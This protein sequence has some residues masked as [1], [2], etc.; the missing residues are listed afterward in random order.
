MVYFYQ[1]ILQI[2]KYIEI[3]HIHTNQIHAPHD[4]RRSAN[5]LNSTA[6]ALYATIKGNDHLAQLIRLI[7]SVRPHKFHTMFKYNAIKIISWF[8]KELIVNSI[9]ISY[10][11]SKVKKFRPDLKYFHPEKI[12]FMI[13]DEFLLEQRYYLWP[14][15]PFKCLAKR[16]YKLLTWTM[17]CWMFFNVCNNSSFRLH[18]VYNAICLGAPGATCTDESIEI[19][20]FIFQQQQTLNFKTKM[21]SGC[22]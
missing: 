4:C 11:W 1:S 19:G 12:D 10:L 16:I 15:H 18:D 7:F 8:K 21:D 14:R 5:S 22:L 13:F 6:H 17:H 9:L 3:Q 2:W 20:I